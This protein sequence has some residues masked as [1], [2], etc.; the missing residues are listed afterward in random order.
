MSRH[1]LVGLCLFCCAESPTAAQWGSLSGRFIY[2]GP[3]P[4][5]KRVNV[6]KD[7]EFCGKC[8]PKDESLV[9]N[10]ENGGIANIVVVVHAATGQP[11][12]Q[13]HP[14]YET[15]AKDDVHLDNVGCRF[16]PHVVRA[17]HRRRPWSSA[18]KTKSATTP[19]S[20]R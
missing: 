7:V 13:P 10:P 3:A 18:I 11:K 5:V 16:Q 12:P 17:A 15:S 19:K 20:T 4:A 14:Q 1:L 6:T 9:V 2:D 8:D